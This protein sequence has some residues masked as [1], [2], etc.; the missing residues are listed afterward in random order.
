MNWL[1]EAEFWFHIPKGY[2]YFAMGFSLLVEILN[3]KARKRRSSFPVRALTL[4]ELN[5]RHRSNETIR[6]ARAQILQFH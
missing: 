1:F 3:I 6:Q 5:Q 2:T 4:G